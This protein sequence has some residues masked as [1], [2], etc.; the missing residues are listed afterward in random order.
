MQAFP[1]LSALLVSDDRE[2]VAACRRECAGAAAGRAD[3]ELQNRCACGCSCR[4]T[5][6]VSSLTTERFDAGHGEVEVR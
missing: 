6:G 2:E 5:G 4:E 3:L 1:T